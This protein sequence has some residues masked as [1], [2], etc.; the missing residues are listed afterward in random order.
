MELLFL[1]TPPHRRIRVGTDCSGIEA[2][3]QALQQLGI[4]FSHEFS[5]EVDPYCIKS[6]KANYKP[7]VLFKD[8]TKRDISKVPDIDLYVCG[9]PCQP[10][11]NAG[12]RKGFRDKRGN[13]FWSCLE[14]IEQKQPTYFILENV[15]AL[16]HHDNGKTWKT[17]WDS[18][19]KL[20][21]NLHY[22]ILNT[23]NYGIPQNRERL[24]II[25]TKE[26]FEFP[27]H[28]PL[29]DLKE[30]VSDTGDAKPT[31]QRHEDILAKLKDNS[32]YVEFAFGVSTTRTFSNSHRVAP[33][34]TAN[35]RIWCVPHHRYATPQELLALQGFGDFVQVVSNTQLKRQIG[36]SMS[37]NVLRALLSK[38]L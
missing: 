38:L 32:V 30:Y 31:S 20:D 21:Y 33:C 10:F 28:T 34:I 16:L 5:S 25:G 23:K 35:P 27:D 15:K 18:L 1:N 36:N 37:V 13:V 3:I 4:P 9:F 2:P 11:S 24:Y 14:V 6:I 29:D 17:I 19:S 8:I 22:Q 26:S 7:K 12:N